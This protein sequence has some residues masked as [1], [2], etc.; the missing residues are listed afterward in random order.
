[1]YMIDYLDR[2]YSLLTRTKVQQFVNMLL[3]VQP[4]HV[5]C[6]TTTVPSVLT[7]TQGLAEVADRLCEC[8]TQPV[9]K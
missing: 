8:F 4:M 3:L 2:E 5:Q 1:M 6:A 9:A 7:A